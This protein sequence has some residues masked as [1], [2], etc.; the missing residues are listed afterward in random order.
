MHVWDSMR[1]RYAQQRTNNAMINDDMLKNFFFLWLGVG[2][3]MHCWVH[4]RNAP[5]LQVVRLRR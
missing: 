3:A 5:S 4:H 2:G 1:M